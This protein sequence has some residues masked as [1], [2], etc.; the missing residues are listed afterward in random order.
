MLFSL[1][2]KLEPAI[3]RVLHLYW[4]LSRGMTLGVRG[5]VFDGEGRV[6]LIRHTYV[7]GWQLPGGGV[8]IGETMEDALRREL[9]EEGNIE[10]TGTP[11]LHG[12]FFQRKASR[13]DHVAVYVIRAFRQDGFPPP[14]REIAE[15][16]YFDPKSLPKETTAGT[17]QRI[18][19]VLGEVPVISDWS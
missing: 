17:R 7:A 8:E 4:W 6:F 1:R 10:V 12:I 11:G 9:F 3:R 14:N 19:E 18:S 16:G 5:V 2:R 15:C 13:R